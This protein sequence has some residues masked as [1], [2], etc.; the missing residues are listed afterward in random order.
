VLLAFVDESYNRDLFCLTCLM[1]DEHVAVRLTDALNAIIGSVAAQ[2]YSEAVEFHGHEMFQ[3]VGGW[4]D[5]PVRLRMNAYLQA[6]RAISASGAKSALVSVE[7]H[8]DHGD[9]TPPHEVALE[10]LLALIQAHAEETHNHVLVLADDVHS[11]ERHRTNFR[12]YQ[13]GRSAEHRRLG[14]ILDTL[15]FGP[16]HHSRLLQAADL[17][18]YMRL[19]RLTVTETDPRAQSVND[20]IWNQLGSTVTA[21]DDAPD[22]HEGSDQKTGA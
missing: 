4:K 9:S 6:A 14:R 18:S 13:D 19:R 3:A 1:A 20:A 22:K 2:G 5:V 16:S 15:Y 12:F 8:A 7:R 17:V 11:A 21:V 10:R